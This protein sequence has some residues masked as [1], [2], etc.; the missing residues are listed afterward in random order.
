MAERTRQ[1]S[2]HPEKR[3]RIG[4][5]QLRSI[6]D[7]DNFL[8]HPD[9]SV[10]RDEAVVDSDIDGGLVVLEEPVSTVD[11]VRFVG[12]LRQ[13]GFRAYHQIEIDVAREEE[14]AALA[15]PGATVSQIMAGLGALTEMSSARVSF[16]TRADIEES[17]DR[18]VL[19][20]D[21]YVYLAG[22]PIVE[23]P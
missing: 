8:C 4:V 23:S 11:E 12:V 17:L 9:C 15:D 7:Y 13:Q 22:T 3:I 5:Q 10:A 1:L 18:G 21:A 6:I 19:D 16:R 20:S 2:D 14:K